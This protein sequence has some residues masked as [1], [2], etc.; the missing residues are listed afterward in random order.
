MKTFLFSL[1]FFVTAVS[2]SYALDPATG[3]IILTLQG[4]IT[5][6]NSDNRAELDRE[7]LQK[8]PQHSITTETPWTEGKKT[9]SGPMLRDVL[10]LVG[11][12]GST[13]TM[14]AINDYSV[15]VPVEDSVRYDTILALRLDGEILTVRSKGP[16]WLIYPWSTN[17]KLRTETYYSRS[18]W[19]LKSIDIV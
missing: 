4:K 16:L 10:A 1:L 17:D 9:F 11:A 2:T 5:V 7:T 18:I 19:Q 15:Q 14:I 8:L 3:E 6:T 12:A 13:L